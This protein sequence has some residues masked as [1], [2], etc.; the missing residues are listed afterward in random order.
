[1]IVA[2]QTARLSSNSQ[3]LTGGPRRS[4]CVRS[5]ARLLALS[6]VAVAGAAALLAGSAHAAAPRIVIV[7]GKALQHQVVISNWMSIFRVVEAVSSSRSVESAQLSGRPHLK[8]AMFWGPRWTEYLSSGRRASALR[9]RDA[10][11]FGTFYPAWHG[12][13][14]LLK[15]PWA[16]RWPRLVPAKA[17]ATLR[18]YGVPTRIR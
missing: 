11:Q 16:G 12:E 8:V 3:N 15:L 13:G 10:D 1:M 2:T 17:L 18:H 4:T 14:A 7:S 5:R 6:A 9:P